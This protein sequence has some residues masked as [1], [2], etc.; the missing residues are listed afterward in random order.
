MAGRSRE[1][2]GGVREQ[3][4]EAEEGQEGDG[5]KGTWALARLQSGGVRLNTGCS[6][7][8]RRLLVL[9]SFSHFWQQSA[10]GL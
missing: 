9:P 2:E 4:P 10:S 7:S 1:Q 5:E 3:F 6:S 8:R